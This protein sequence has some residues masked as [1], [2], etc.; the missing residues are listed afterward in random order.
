MSRGPAA[1]EV[2]NGVRL[3][4]NPGGG[5]RGRE[6]EAGGTD[7]SAPGWIGNWA[8]CCSCSA[9]LMTACSA[10]RNQATLLSTVRSCL[11]CVPSWLST[12][13][14]NCSLCRK[15]SSNCEVRFQVSTNSA[16]N[17]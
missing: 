5:V 4:D 14:S 1:P 16:S 3:S 2:G 15:R 7:E 12:L 6:G 8:I 11:D 10:E 13:L 9:L 17:S